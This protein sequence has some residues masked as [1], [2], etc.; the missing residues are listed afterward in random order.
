MI[1][2]L[3]SAATAAQETSRK[4]DAFNDLTTD[5]AQAHL[6]LF[7]QEL[8]KDDK[9][10]LIVGYRSRATLPG[11]HLRRIFGYLDYLVNSRGVR[12][13]NLDVV[14]AGPANNTLIELWIMSPGANKPNHP[15]AS[16]LIPN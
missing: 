12:P 1:C 14:D 2:C 5:D 4:F 15:N 10:G 16:R 11:S 3:G 6:D 7:A 13:E 9:L 8:T